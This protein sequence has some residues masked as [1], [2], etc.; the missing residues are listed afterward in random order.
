[1]RWTALGGWR[2]PRGGA[3]RP[4]TYEDG[5]ESL[6][7]QVKDPIHYHNAPPFIH[8]STHPSIHPSIHPINRPNH[9]L[10]PI[11]IQQRLRLPDGFEWCGPWR[12]LRTN[13][14][15]AQG[16]R[17]AN[18][19]RTFDSHHSGSSARS[20]S[21]RARRRRWVRPMRRA[22]VGAEEEGVG[23]RQLRSVLLQGE[24]DMGGEGLEGTASGDGA[25]VLGGGGKGGEALVLLLGEENMAGAELLLPPPQRR[26]A[27]TGKD[28][29]DEE[30]A[31]AEEEGGPV[32]SLPELAD[33]IQ[34]AARRA[35]EEWHFKG[36]TFTF[37][38]SLVRK[39][40]G[41]GA[42]AQN[43]YMIF[44]RARLLSF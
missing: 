3:V 7:P 24:I 33:V 36:F 4:W 29:D 19:A 14:T 32:G 43:V 31:A 11:P 34:T 22:A 27:G 16:W 30:E 18:R 37:I 40:F 38:K 13:F 35:R 6:N 15:D 17:Y 26:R 39:D 41:L 42:C 20:L 28:D 2:R 21:D 25:L 1:M 5:G 8:P 9:I 10:C 44:L 12:V 23:V